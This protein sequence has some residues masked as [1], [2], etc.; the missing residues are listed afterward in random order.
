M[1]RKNLFNRRGDITDMMVFL[2]VLFIL[3][4][5]LVI[6]VYTISAMT[7]GLNVAGLNET[8]QT[9]EAIDGLDNFG[10]IVLQR[11]F[12]L[13]F[14]GLIISVMITSFFA[15][16][17]PIWLFLYVIMLGLTIFIGIYLGSAFEEM[18]EVDILTDVISNQP[19]ISFV[20]NNIL[21]IITAVG[22]LSLII[23]FAKFKLGKMG[24][25]I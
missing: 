1:E 3:A 24:G 2:I 10:T 23:V 11:G 7:D 25:E 8:T 12:L 18:Q 14:V 5:G 15:N 6:I 19:M 17:H 21:I 4:V 9:S 13:L 22:V 16:T 20:M